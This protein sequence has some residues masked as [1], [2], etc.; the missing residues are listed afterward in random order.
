[1]LLE[2]QAFN[3]LGQ[4]AVPVLPRVRTRPG[5]V[6]VALVLEGL[7]GGAVGDLVLLELVQVLGALQHHDHRG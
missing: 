5:Q 3:P 2:D 6:Q 4:P 1:M 7:G